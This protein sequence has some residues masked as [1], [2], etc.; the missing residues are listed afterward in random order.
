VRLSLKQLELA[1]AT[2]S[3]TAKDGIES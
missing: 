1:K 3:A 2:F